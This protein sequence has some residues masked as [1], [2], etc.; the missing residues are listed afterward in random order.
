MIK[1][2][3]AVDFPVFTGSFVMHNPLVSDSSG[4]SEFYML[5]TSSVPRR[6]EGEDGGHLLG[7]D[8]RIPFEAAV[9][10]ERY[11]ANWAFYDMYQHPSCSLDLTSSW[12]GEG[13][14]LYKMKAHNALASMI[15]FFLPGQDNRG[16]LTTF[17]SRPEK[18]FGRFKEGTTY[19]MRVKLRK[20]YN[21]PRQVGN[22][23]TRGY[24][25]PNDSL[26]DYLS[27]GLRETFTMYSRPSAFGPA[28]AGRNN[29][30]PASSSNNS[31]DA[32]MEPDSMFGINPSFTPP[33]Y[34]GEAWADILY[35]HKS[36][37]QPTINDII[38][39]SQLVCWRWDPI[40]LGLTDN[41]KPY[42]ADNI[43]LYSMQLTSSINLFGVSKNKVIEYT[44]DGTPSKVYDDVTERSNV[45]TIQPK[46]ETPMLD[47]SDTQYEKITHVGGASGSQTRGMWH[48]FGKMPKDAKD[49]IFLEVNDIDRGWL[50]RR[51]PLFKSGSFSTS[52]GVSSDYRGGPN[53]GRL[54]P[55]R[56]YTNYQTVY[57]NGDV[58]SLLDLVKFNKTSARLGE[59]A[60]Q[61]IVKEAVVAVPYI[62]IG[63][64]RK[65]FNV[66]KKQ[67]NGA[68][69]MLNGQDTSISV[70]SSVLEMVSKMQDYVFPPKMDCVKYPEQVKPIA[71]YIFEFEH[72]FSQDD[73][74]YM[75]QNIRPL[76]AKSIK[77]ATATVSHRLLTDELM[78][79][80]AKNTNKPIQDRL[81]WM[82]FKVKQKASWDYYEKVVEE[83]K[84]S[85]SR[86]KSDFKLGRSNAAAT[87]ISEIAD[88]N[89]NWP[90]DNFSL[91]EFIK[92]ES[93]IKFSDD[94]TPEEQ[95]GRPETKLKR[96]RD[97]KIK[98]A[99]NNS[100]DQQSAA[101]A[102]LPAPTA[103][104]PQS[105][106]PSG[107]V[108]PRD[109]IT[110][111]NVA[112]DQ[113]IGLAP[114]TL[115]SVLGLSS[116]APKSKSIATKKAT[117]ATTKTI[118]ST[119]RS[120]KYNK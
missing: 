24:L 94:W 23:F 69:R 99:E 92:L 62:Q 5:S 22:R 81:R 100:I 58:E 91:V 76:S 120:N 26:T 45:W 46:M 9:D 16:E 79:S 89:Y 87:K 106:A 117:G 114:S 63:N 84:N 50:R 71:M 118:S 37:F 102:A 30:S 7:W 25:T 27:A 6:T 53:I 97:S 28:V 4:S 72:T 52:P 3:L 33:Y 67:I 31:Y 104:G 20:S 10:P 51:V 13:D 77:K 110:I 47:F 43:N 41:A 119:R 73:L 17:T 83:Q 8:Y 59:L 93:E 95:Q 85:D 68:L 14:S 116:V 66:P 21:V 61:R 35:T 49:G 108:S 64:R 86:Y 40:H 56:D 12:G 113:P 29:L 103:G 57:N 1:S 88:Y 115:P 101:T 112:A 111:A 34:D 70:G 75:W 96:S 42:G 36:D 44:A 38:T 107:M 18:E 65:F 98:K 82:V 80:V 19:G 90:Y 74:S 15:D 60:N 39:G 109:N 48:Q 2:G 11:M 54:A 32:I 55:V 105:L 78:G